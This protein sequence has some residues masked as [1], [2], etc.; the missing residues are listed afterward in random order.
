MASCAGGTATTR[1]PG[2]ASATYNAM[3]RPGARSGVKGM[4]STPWIPSRCTRQPPPLACTSSGSATWTGRVQP[5]RRHACV[6]A[7][8]RRGVAVDG[9]LA[10][11]LRAEA[12]TTIT[13][14]SRLNWHDTGLFPALMQAGQDVH[15]SHGLFYW[16]RARQRGWVITRGPAA[17]VVAWRPD[18]QRLVVLRPVGDAVAAADL[19]DTVTRA[20][21]L[22]VPGARLVARYCGQALA[23]VLLDRGWGRFSGVWS[24]G[25]PRDDEAHPEV[26]ITGAPTGMPPGR[27][28]E[29]V[30]EAVRWH[31][32]AYRFHASSRLLTGGQQVPGLSAA[33]VHAGLG[34]AV[35]FEAAVASALDGRDRTQLTY[36]YLHHGSQARGVRDHGQHHRGRP[37]LLPVDHPRAPAGDL[38]P[39]A[40]LPAR[41]QQRGQRTQP[42]RLGNSLLVPLQDQ[43]L[44]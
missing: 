15:G 17:V 29:S 22:A 3:T 41:A 7:A 14:L 24:P 39:V 11:E 20:A 5:G 12:G 18:V 30:R 10:A 35:S 37:R 9:V 40:D 36:H 33:Q 25:T 8:Q 2:N 13:L 1:K 43:D 19:L 31:H 32:G 28:F 34:D 44:P 42:R 6:G 21:A 26:I 23:Q 27:H 4:S 16:L 38:L